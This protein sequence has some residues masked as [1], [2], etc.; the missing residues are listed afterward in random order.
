MVPPKGDHQSVPVIG[1]FPRGTERCSGAST[2]KKKKS[3][4]QMV[5]MKYHSI[6]NLLFLGKV[7]ERAVVV[8]LQIFMDDDA[9]LDSFQFNF[10]PGHRM[11]TM[12]FA[13]MDDL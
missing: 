13:F 3:L 9:Y 10:Y 7:V 4:D 1:N 8:Q 6:S 5:L 12:L 2:T 11:E